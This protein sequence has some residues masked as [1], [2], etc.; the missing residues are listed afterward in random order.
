VSS[1]QSCNISFSSLEGL[2]ELVLA[3][4][5]FVELSS[6]NQAKVNVLENEYSAELG[7]ANLTLRINQNNNDKIITRIFKEP[8]MK[9]EITNYSPYCEKE[10]FISAENLK[11]IIVSDGLLLL[12]EKSGIDGI[13][14]D[15]W[16]YYG[17]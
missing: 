8:G 13:P 16:V 10:G 3:G 1:E 12:E 9:E 5:D 15:L 11:A 4:T 17:L 2:P 6:F 14:S 7:G